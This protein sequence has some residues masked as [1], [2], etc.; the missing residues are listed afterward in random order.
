M[1]LIESA[2]RNWVP[3]SD[4]PAD[5][6]AAFLGAKND[7]LISSRRMM[8]AVADNLK[9]GGKWQ[10]FNQIYLQAY[11]LNAPGSQEDVAD[12]QNLKARAD[13]ALNTIRTRPA[14]PCSGSSPADART[15]W[16]A[17]KQAAQAMVTAYDARVSKMAT[18]V[19][20]ADRIITVT[21]P[22]K[23]RQAQAIRDA[24]MQREAERLIQETR[25]WKTKGEQEGTR[26]REVQPVAASLRQIR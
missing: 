7:L 1:R 21:G 20:Q 22:A 19:Q 11:N 16:E 10:D 25:E 15:H 23:V 8:D 18:F 3:I 4:R 2:K 13:A 24:A 14:N 17:I 9:L 6:V 26:L 12:V 5:K